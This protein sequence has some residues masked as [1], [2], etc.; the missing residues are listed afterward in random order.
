MDVR[1]DVRPTVTSTRT[2]PNPAPGRGKARPA[3]SSEM[4]AGRLTNVHRSTRRAS[5][6]HSSASNSYPVTGRSSPGRRSSVTGM[7]AKEE[8]RGVPLTHLDEP[9]FDGA[10]ETK[11]DLV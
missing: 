8:R 2:A 10:D 6:N 7:E 1:H 4:S 9:L 3:I 11:R 5:H